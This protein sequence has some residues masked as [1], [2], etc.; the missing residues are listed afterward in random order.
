M[1]LTIYMY[2]VGKIAELLQIGLNNTVLHQLA[3]KTHSWKAELTHFH[4]FL[5]FE[6]LAQ[7]ITAFQLLEAFYTA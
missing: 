5:D 7:Y 3:S 2:I 4:L 6:E 1:I